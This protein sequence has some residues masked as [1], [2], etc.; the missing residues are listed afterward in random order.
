MPHPTI[1]L[2]PLTKRA[3]VIW[4]PSP[5]RGDTHSLDGPRHASSGGRPAF[6][7]THPGGTVGGMEP[8]VVV[9]GFS[10]VTVLFGA[11]LA[12]DR[13]HGW[14][15]RVAGLIGVAAALWLVVRVH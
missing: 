12:A 13:S 10:A 9:A 15:I 2:H 7:V 4:S 8:T 1:I 3:T 5:H 14:W 6:G 11:A